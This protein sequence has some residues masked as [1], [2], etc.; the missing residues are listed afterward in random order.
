MVELRIFSWSYFMFVY[1]EN[2][3]LQFGFDHTVRFD[4]IITL[5]LFENLHLKMGLYFN[6]KA[7]S[8]IW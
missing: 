7:I 8:F 2:Y 5:G 6:L 3:L 4:V 1:N